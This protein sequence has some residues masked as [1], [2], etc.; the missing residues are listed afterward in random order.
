MK[1]TITKILSLVLAL[2]MLVSTTACTNDAKL[3]CKDFVKLNYGREDI[4][5]EFIDM[6]YNFSANLFSQTMN[7]QRSRASVN[8]T[9]QD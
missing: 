5:Q 2:I 1:K 8:Y 6:M 9:W 4:S 7:D 3:I